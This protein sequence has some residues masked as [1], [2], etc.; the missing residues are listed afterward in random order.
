MVDPVRTP[1]TSGIATKRISRS[2]QHEWQIDGL[3]AAA[4]NAWLE[5]TARTAPTLSPTVRLINTIQ[6]LRKDFEVSGTLQAIDEIGIDS[7]FNKELRDAT[8]ELSRDLELATLRATYAQGNATVAR[9][10]MGLWQ[11]LVT[12]TGVGSVATAC[13]GGNT[14]TE[15]TWNDI[16]QE[17]YDGSGALPDEALLSSRHKRA[18]AGFSGNSTFFMDRNDKRLINAIDLYEGD[19]GIQKLFISD[20]MYSTAAS[21][22]YVVYRN[23]YMAKPILRDVTKHYADQGDSTGGSVIVEGTLEVRAPKSCGLVYGQLVAL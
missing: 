13:A 23:E 16:L 3:A 6:L 10:M 11:F 4:A 5:G 14:F 17:I 15:A 2:P 21:S 7:R 8:A 19:F 20:Y 18:V 22:S 12:H 9:S 1:F